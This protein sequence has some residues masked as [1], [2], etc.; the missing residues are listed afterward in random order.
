MDIT[1]LY[2]RNET[3]NELPINSYKM[4][5]VTDEQEASLNDLYA[6]L[7]K[8]ESNNGSSGN[9]TLF[10]RIAAPICAAVLIINNMMHDLRN[11]FEHWYVN[12]IYVLVAVVLVVLCKK[13]DNTKPVENIESKE[14]IEKEIKNRHYKCMG[15]EQDCV[16]VDFVFTVYKSTGDG[17]INVKKHMLLNEIECCTKDGKLCIIDEEMVT[18]GIS[19]ADM[20]CIEKVLDKFSINYIFMEEEYKQDKYVSIG[21]D[22][23]EGS[24]T[25]ESLYRIRLKD[26]NYALYFPSYELD[27]IKS[28]TGLEYNEE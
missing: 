7:N 8:A 14:E 28:L 1:N 5:E 11:F 20:I 16:A 10:L 22:K 18:F 26:D 24:V 3:S 19:L 6:K 17:N 2:S 23:D 25:V 27:T 13:L 21:I 9:K 4:A 12:L 15:I